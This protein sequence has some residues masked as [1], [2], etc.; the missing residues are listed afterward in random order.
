MKALTL[1]SETDVA[2]VVTLHEAKEHLR[3]TLDAEDDRTFIELD[4]AI[5]QAEDFTRRPIR[6]A[7]YRFS[8]DQWRL[9]EGVNAIRLNGF[10]SAVDSIEYRDSNGT[11]QTIATSVYDTLIGQHSTLIR[12]APNQSW[13]ELAEYMENIRVTFTAGWSHTDVP[14]QVK[15]GVLMFLLWV[16]DADSAARETAEQ[17]LAPWRLPPW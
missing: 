11:L 5:S 9:V 4:A 7:Q 2:Q 13:P 15:L 8:T 14:Y 17:I 16:H 6:R 3:I 1:V 10:V 12:E